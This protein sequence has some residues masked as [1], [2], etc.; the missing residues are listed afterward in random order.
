MEGKR[1]VLIVVDMLN[2]FVHP[3]GALFCGE[4][5]RKIIPKVAGLIG[6]F[7]NAGDKVIYLQDAHSE[8]DLEFRLFPRHA[9]RGS[10]GSEIVEELK[11]GE[12]EPVIP[13]TRFSGFFR[14]D[15]ERILEEIKPF[16]V[17]VVGVCTSI[18]VM[19]TV[20]DLRNR[21]YEVVV[22]AECVA[23]FD[24]EMHECALKRMERIYRVRLI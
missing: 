12:G 24:Q 7:R 8:D 2:D 20:A 18:C 16:E 10:W 1:R 22:P 3:Q 14:T 6:E 11:P 23:D 4:G 15:L 9:V 19:D 17:W 21:D 5:A 13:K